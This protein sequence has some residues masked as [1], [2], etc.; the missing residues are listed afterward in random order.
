MFQPEPREDYGR[1]MGGRKMGGNASQTAPPSVVS[2]V[3]G[4][5][6]V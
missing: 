3:R 6:G 1:K 5:S 2:D 4:L